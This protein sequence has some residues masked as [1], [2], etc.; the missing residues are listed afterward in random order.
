MSEKK[1]LDSAIAAEREKLKKLEEK[2][3]KTDQQIKACKSSLDRLVM[4]R[5]NQIFSDMSNALDEKGVRIEEVL[6]AIKEGDISSLQ[7]RI[8]GKSEE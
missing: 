8:A 6:E 4:L 2:R 7:D 1:D 5:N 3:A